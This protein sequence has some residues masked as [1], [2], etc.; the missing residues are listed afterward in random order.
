MLIAY[1]ATGTL[2]LLIITRRT[3]TSGHVVYNI[4]PLLFQE[5]VFAIEEFDMTTLLH[6]CE[7]N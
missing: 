2:F 4:L 7:I 1:I 3:Y 5:Y 6:F